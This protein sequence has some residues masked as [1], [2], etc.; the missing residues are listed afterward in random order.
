MKRRISLITILVASGL[1]AHTLAQIQSV[2]LEHPDEIITE[3]IHAQ[4]YI[5]YLALPETTEVATSLDIQQ[6]RY[7][8]E[9]ELAAALSSLEADTAG[10][11]SLRGD[12]ET[13][14]GDGPGSWFVNPAWV[15]LYQNCVLQNRRDLRNFGIF[16]E[17]RLANIIATG[18]EEGATLQT[19]LIDRLRAKH[20]AATRVIDQELRTQRKFVSYYNTGEKTY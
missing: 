4:T 16:L 19:E 18:G 13:E 1:P 2:P 9:I 3:E 10:C 14:I 12:L 17:Q 5:N 20:S 6:L 15:K 8:S 7:K 11:I